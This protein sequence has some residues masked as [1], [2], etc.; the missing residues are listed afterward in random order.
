MKLLYF[1]LILFFA[2][3]MT[4]IAHGQIQEASAS[5]KNKPE[6]E[7][8]LK[9]AGFGMFI[10]WGIDSQLG[11]VISHSLVGA[12]EDY[13]DRY[14]EQLPRNFNPVDWNPEKIATLAENAGMQYVVFTTKHHAG[15]CFWDTETTDF[16]VT[17][18]PYQKDILGE[19]VEALRRHGLAVGFYYSPEDFLYY[20]QQGVKD[21]RR[22]NHW[23][24]APQIHD[25]YLAYTRAQINE[26][27]KNYGQVDLFFI[28]SEVMLEEVK[29]LVW[30]NQP[31][32]LITRG[33]LPTPEQSVPG[34]EIETAWESCMTMGTQWN[35]K[36]TNEHYKS[37][38]LLI[39][40]LIEARA[41]GGSFLLNVGPGPWGDL[42]E[43]QQGRLI[44][45]AA[46]NFVNQEAIQDVRPWAV[47]HEGDIWFTRHRENNTVYA[48]L[49]NQ[50]NWTRGDRKE[51]L[52]RSV[53]ATADTK[54]SVLG[55]SGNLVEYQPDT[56]GTAR[57]EAT[58]EGLTVSV[59]RAQRIYNNHQWPNPI[60]VKLENVEPALRPARFATEPARVDADGTITFALEI[61]EVGGGQA[62]KGGFEYRRKQSTLSENFDPS[63]KST[64]LFPVKEPGAYQLEITDPELGRLPT[65]ES[66]SAK[67]ANPSFLEGGVE[68]RAVLYQD[69]LRLEGGVE[70]LSE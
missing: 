66:G 52:L 57:F 25:K 68:Y 36:P 44:E 61:S 69:G 37:G 55:Q 35:Y 22:V 3:V 5:N 2:L 10:H 62:F 20:Y 60:V 30:E 13:V 54:I 64:S 14:I 49:T 42:N 46:W 34:E 28:D 56:D 50:P 59:V 58:D 7:E 47:S 1:N 27:T 16:N 33:A 4:H 48:Y 65:T 41:R 38:T 39:N 53:K 40:L 15:F 32:C 31:N 70:S 45:I 11:M 63:W 43:G 26:L 9:D 21:I 24:S 67:V 6:R 23:K 29:E 12:S 17:N 8:W 51:F 19:L 18:T